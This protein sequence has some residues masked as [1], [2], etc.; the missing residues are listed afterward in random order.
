MTAFRTGV[1]ILAIA[2][3]TAPGFADDYGV[4]PTGRIGPRTAPQPAIPAPPPVPYPLEGT[5]PA[6]VPVT[7][8]AFDQHADAPPVQPPVEAPVEQ[9]VAPPIAPPV[10]GPVI[11]EEVPPP[12]EF[13]APP[14]APQVVMPVAPPAAAPRPAKRLVRRPRL[15]F[16]VHVEGAVSIFEDPEG[17]LGQPVAAG[18]TPYDWALN[19][20]DPSIGGRLGLSWTPGDCYRY[21]IRG[22]HYG[23]VDAASS[24]N[25]SFGFFPPAGG[26]SPAAT[27]N[28]ASEAELY[29]AEA[30]FWYEEKSNECLCLSY[31]IGFR[32]V[33]HEDEASVSNLPLPIP[34]AA[35]MIGSLNGE[36]ENEFFG[37]QLMFR[38]VYTPPEF[39]AFSIDLS[40]KALLGSLERRI[41]INDT[42]ILAG[43]P[44]SAS[45]EL[46]DFGWGA[47]VRLGFSYEITRCLRATL[48]YE[49]FYLADVSRAHSSFDFSQAQTGAVQAG[50]VTEDLI[51]HSLFFG[52]SYD[53]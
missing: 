24:Q 18:N 23:E 44:H 33:N 39:D 28:F 7:P 10:E 5:T 53:F 41:R 31:G 51:I 3:L 26:T 27:A 37:G 9:P 43:G 21:E 14:C 22:T 2:L 1:A 45:R 42:S 12:V 17:G 50:D 35:P 40:V 47:E 36:V 30:N 38:G 34:G 48:A 8:G 52:L 25:G 20:F 15:Q 16:R 13:V 32:Y 46:D 4:A 49:L 29:T 11:I 19:E 6:P